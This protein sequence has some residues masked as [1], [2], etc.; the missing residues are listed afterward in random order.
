MEWIE[1]ISSIITTLGIPL[2]AFIF[3]F[4]SKK[5]SE[6]AKAKKDE[7]DARRAEGDNITHY[8]AEWKE[9]Y[10]KKEAKVL[11]YERQ[12]AEDR[13]RIRELQ[14]ENTKLKLEVTTLSFYKCEKKGCKDRMPP[15]QYL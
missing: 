13:E 15:N 11:D 4:D 1:T 2:L 5:R 10:E 3:F 8:A 14:E 9:L 7:E 12:Q 6:A